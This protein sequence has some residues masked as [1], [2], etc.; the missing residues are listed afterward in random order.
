[1]FPAGRILLLYQ[2]TKNMYFDHIDTYHMIYNTTATPPQSTIQSL[3]V[4]ELKER[5]FLEVYTDFTP[6]FSH[7][8]PIIESYRIFPI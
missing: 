1:L 5:P 2:D 8:K 6:V 4:Y 3:H 7:Q